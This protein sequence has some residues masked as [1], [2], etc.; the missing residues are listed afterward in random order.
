M[1]A[2]FSA[3]RGV[4]SQV[5]PFARRQMPIDYEKAI[6]QPQADRIR[7]SD[8]GDYVRWM[9]ADPPKGTPNSQQSGSN[10]DRNDAAPTT[11]CSSVPKGYANYRGIKS[12][13]LNA[14]ENGNR[15]HYEVDRLPIRIAPSHCTDDQSAQY[16]DQWEPHVRGGTRHRGDCLP[17]ANFEPWPLR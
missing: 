15:R 8:S 17:E 2:T 9:T 12:S 5:A 16:R 7:I 11:R 6:S 1:D 13:S 3:P 4:T 10:I 14:H